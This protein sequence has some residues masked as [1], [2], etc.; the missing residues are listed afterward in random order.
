MQKLILAFCFLLFFINTSFAQEEKASYSY[1]AQQYGDYKIVALLDG[2]NYLNP[3]LFTNLSQDEKTRILTKYGALDK[4]GIQTPVNAF[5]VDDGKNLT[6][7]DSGA[8]SCYGPHLGSIS[9]NIELAGYKLED[10][11]TVLLTHLHPDH[12]CGITQN[13]KTVYPNAT[14]YA[15]E[16]E[17]DFWLNPEKEKTIPDNKK[18]AYLST[19]KLIKTAIKPY[20]DKQAFK[21]FKDGDKIQDFEIIDTRGHTPGH[22]SFLLDNKGQS[23]VFIGDIVHSHSLQFD[24]PK[25]AVEFD[26]DQEQAINTRLKMFDR[27][28]SKNNLIADDANIKRK[29]V[30]PSQTN[31]LVAAPHLPFPGIGKIYKV[32]DE[33]YQ[34]ITISLDKNLNK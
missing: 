17:V 13:E 28:S 29:A 20:E 16:R 11:K 2:T 6:L 3:D 23:I 32:N 30:T 31:D 24:A 27:L 10:I 7:V 8:A 21:T 34:W 1:Y 25:T 22:H 5:L 18:E 9:K 4:R 33:Q 26:V 12:V 14:V 15:H 19:I